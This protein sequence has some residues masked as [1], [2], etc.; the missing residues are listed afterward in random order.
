MSLPHNAVGWSAVCAVFICSISVSHN[1]GYIS[2][3]K[4]DNNLLYL[5]IQGAG[6]LGAREGVMGG[7]RGG[8]PL[9]LPLSYYDGPVSI[10]CLFLTVL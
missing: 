10:L 1:N 4:V 5:T 6:R 7:Q 2:S 9:D 8:Y 3:C